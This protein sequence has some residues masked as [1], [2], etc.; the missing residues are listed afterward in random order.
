M[1]G[2]G[3][4]GRGKSLAQV[5]RVQNGGGGGGLLLLQASSPTSPVDPGL[6]LVDAELVGMLRVLQEH[7]GRGKHGFALLAGEMGGLPG[8]WKTRRTK[9][10]SSDRNRC[11]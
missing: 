4:K 3:L 2:R 6:L 11:P 9:V 5:A 7:P 10:S 1:Q 8:G